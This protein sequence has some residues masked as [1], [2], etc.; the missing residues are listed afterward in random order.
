[1][2]LPGKKVHRI[3]VKQLLSAGIENPEKAGREDG[4]M[5]IGFPEGVMIHDLVPGDHLSNQVKLW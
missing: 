4:L 3:L 5:M 1:M 2:I